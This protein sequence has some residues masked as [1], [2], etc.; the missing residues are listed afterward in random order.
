MRKCFQSKWLTLLIT[1]T[2]AV[3]DWREVAVTE[4]V[5]GQNHCW[6]R[7]EVLVI[8]MKIRFYQWFPHTYMKGR[9]FKGKRRPCWL[10]QM[11]CLCCLHTSGAEQLL[12]LASHQFYLFRFD[13]VV[14]FSEQGS[15]FTYE[16]YRS[17]H[18]TPK[19]LGNSRNEFPFLEEQNKLQQKISLFAV[20]A[21]RTSCVPWW[22]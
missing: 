4:R 7:A 2:V 9:V 17:S 16:T 22:N 14:G 1:E 15:H 21:T 19:C 3:R 8:S 20:S 5:F 18:C 12:N 10:E 11:L 6:K 13:F